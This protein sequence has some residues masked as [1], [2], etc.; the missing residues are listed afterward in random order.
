MIP[1]IPSNADS[2]SPPESGL[3]PKTY[4]ELLP[5]L[6]H[7]TAAYAYTPMDGGVEEMEIVDDE[8]YV[9]GDAFFID[10]MPGSVS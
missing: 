9:I 2:P 7:V 10:Q 1:R 4:V 3:V 5:I 6:R 8:K